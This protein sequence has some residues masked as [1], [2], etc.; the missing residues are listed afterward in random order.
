MTT[1]AMQIKKHNG[2][3]R[4]ILS[5]WMSVI[6][7]PN[8]DTYRAQKARADPLKTV[9][10]ICLLGLVL[11]LWSLAKQLDTMTS[12]TEAILLDLLRVIFFTVAD[13]F[14]LNLFLYLI[15]KVFGGK[16]SFIE[17]SYLFS[18]VTVPLGIFVVA[19]LFVGEKL[20]LTLTAVLNP[21]GPIGVVSILIVLFVVYGFLL[22]LFALQAAHE[23]RSS[24]VVYTLA[25][26][27][28]IWITL[29]VASMFAAQEENAITAQWGF[30]AEQ[31]GKGTAQELLLGHLW[32]VLFSVVIAIVVGVTIGVLISWPSNR[33]RITHLVFLIPLALGLLLWAASSGMLGE[34]VA[35]P[36]VDTVKEWD[37]SLRRLDN[38]YFDGLFAIL[39]AIISKPQALGIIFAVVTVIIYILLIAGEGVSELTL[40]IAG[41]ILTIPSVALFG[42]LIKPLGI[43]P[44]NAAFALILY[45]QL[46]ILRNTYT[47][48]KAVPPEI[49]EA[50]RGMGMSEFQLL[51]KVKLP[52]AI[53]VILTGVRISVV[54]LIGIAA[55][56]A[57]IGND[58]LGEYIFSGI[59]RAQEKRYIA[60]AILV[61]VFAL[62]VDYLLGLLQNAMTPEGLKGRRERS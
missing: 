40:Y 56:A 5:S 9:F 53:P 41:I 20:G 4:E 52:M 15:A 30:I 33:P 50:G 47:G 14:I 13:F 39:A 8:L 2:F 38:L 28:I 45:A 12:G 34:Q 36:I 1:E 37:R 19:F 29:R 59:Q 27:L 25:T 11:G 46:P 51:R 55:I 60:G 7:E 10:G 32:L 35:D 44:F 49:I 57:Y 3:W 31:W 61:A 58:T 48:I 22:L 23:M 16:G 21:L 42:V 54:M 26:P 6:T 62:A 18:L 17:Q 43:G 24:A